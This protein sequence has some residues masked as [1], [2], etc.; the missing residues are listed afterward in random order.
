MLMHCCR[1]ETQNLLALDKERVNIDE[2]KRLT[3]RVVNCMAK[4][5]KYCIIKP[6]G[7][8]RLIA[9]KSLLDFEHKS[10]F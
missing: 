4:K 3:G 2:R 7:A 9:K 5:R 8:K 6:W 10:F 1:M